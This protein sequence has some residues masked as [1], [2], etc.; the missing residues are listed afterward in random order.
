MM[1]RLLRGRALYV[2]LGGI[3]IWLYAHAM[4][5]GHG[6]RQEALELDQPA[7][8]NRNTIDF[9]PDSLDP[10][11]MQ[12][13]AEEQPVVA[14]VASAT[15]LI[16]TGIIILGILF[17]LTGVFSGRLKTLWQFRAAQLP[18]WS[19]EELIRIVLLVVLFA[20]LLPFARY[21]LLSLEP[22]WEIDA[23][24]WVPVSMVFLDAFIVIAIL[25]FAEGKSRAGAWETVGF[26][27]KKNWDSIRLGLRGYTQ[28][29]PWLIL[30][31]Y[32]I[33]GITDRLHWVPP[34]EP[35]QELIF[36]EHRPWVFAVTVLLACFIGPFA[37][38]CFF[39]GVLYPAI[40]HKTSRW[41]AI[42]ISGGLFG[43]VHTNL[44]SFLPIMLLGCLL[45]YV[46]ER[47]GSLAGPF[48]IHAVHNSLLMGMAIV[49]RYIPPAS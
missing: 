28:L 21:V 17:S 43:M 47:S 25:A 5:S 2:A 27:R 18:A 31:L 8:A 1:Q 46:Y 42:L 10:A 35:I 38:E 36:Q 11:A 26:V 13:L 6:L 40:K 22:R 39:R 30:L 48:L 3:M 4:S 24:L 44:V 37:E 23:H 29:F 12:K 16:T 45:A 41:L 33:V 14:W 7:S 19:V 34:A 9:L 15:S 49:Y 32:L 20:G